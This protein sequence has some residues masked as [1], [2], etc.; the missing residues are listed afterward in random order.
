[1][2]NR[3]SIDRR[4]PRPSLVS[5]HK[6]SGEEDDYDNIDS[7]PK[8]MSF[9]ILDAIAILFSIGSFLFDIGTDVAVAIVHYQNRNF[10]YFILTTCFILVPTLVTTG[11]SLRWSYF[12]TD[13]QEQKKYFQYMVYED[14]DA[15]MLRLFECFMEAAPQLVLQIYILAKGPFNDKDYLMVIIQIV[16]VLA[17]LVSLSWSL[18]SYQRALRMSLPDK[19]NL[20]WQAT[21]VQFLWRFFV[22]AA[23]V[24][25]LALFASVYHY[26]ISVVCGVHWVVMFTWIVSMKTTFCE[27]KIEEIG[28][29]I[30][31]AVMFIFCYFNPIDNPTRYRYAA[32]YTFMFL[33]NTFLMCFWYLNVEPYLWYRLPAMIGH[34]LS[35]FTGIMF[36]VAYYLL[37]HPTGEI[38]FFRNPEDDKCE[39]ARQQDARKGGYKRQIQNGLW[40]TQGRML[41]PRPTVPEALPSFNSELRLSQRRHNVRNAQLVEKINSISKGTTV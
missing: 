16:A 30:V 29:N 25:A 38:K 34:F 35:F 32:F 5:L 23:R 8:D 22:I 17:S 28:Y 13:K 27:S 37:L 4:P 31:L 7:I 19:T 3:I 26:W 1:M 40:T 20:T 10:T 6:S 15:A 14:T 11:I 18:V 24:L 39:E 12:K 41:H 33:E 36:M 9:T 2:E 21:A